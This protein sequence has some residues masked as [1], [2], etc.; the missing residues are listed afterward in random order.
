MIMTNFRIVLL[1]LVLIATLMMGCGAGHPTIMSVTVTPSTASAASSSQGT[2]GFTATGNFT[3]NQSRM[4][5]VADG[6][7]WQSSNIPVASI[8]SLGMAT[9]KIPG[10]ATI[11]GSAPANLQ[12]TIGSGVNNTSMTVSGTAMLTCT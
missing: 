10:T 4:L 1:A 5:V 8:N 2:V 6:L 9:C 7:S 11:T 12:F 3:N